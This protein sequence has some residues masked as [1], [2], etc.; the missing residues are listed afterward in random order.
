M[1]ILNFVIRLD[2]IIL[3]TT[4][5]WLGKWLKSRIEELEKDATER[6][7]N[8]KAAIKDAHKSMI[9]VEAS[10]IAFFPALLF[11]V[12]TGFTVYLYFAEGPWAAWH[13]FGV[14]WIIFSIFLFLLDYKNDLLHSFTGSAHRLFDLLP[15]DCKWKGADEEHKRRGAQFLKVR[16]FIELLMAGIGTFL[17]GY[18]DLV[19]EW[20]HSLYA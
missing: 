6:A 19:E 7:E 5:E 17:N 11:L 8:L 15:E 4:A 1:N 9:T 3:S 20:L 13:R 12:L 2:S 14:V 10:V 16:R 18:G